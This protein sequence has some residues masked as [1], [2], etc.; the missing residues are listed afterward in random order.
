MADAIYDF[1][2]W[3]SMKH[4]SPIR[5]DVTEIAPL[6]IIMNVLERIKVALESQVSRFESHHEPLLGGNLFALLLKL[7][8]LGHLKF[9]T[10]LTLN[11]S[12]S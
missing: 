4:Y 9:T 5:S 7:Y 10:N 6:W 11:I 2:L 8:V 12:D 1:E 3:N